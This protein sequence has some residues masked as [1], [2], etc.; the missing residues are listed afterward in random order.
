MKQG[1]S[2]AVEMIRVKH[3]SGMWSTLHFKSYDQGR[4]AF[5]GTEIDVIW[6][7]EEPPLPI[8]TECVTRT[9]TNDGMVMLTFTPLEGMSDVVMAFLNPEGG[10][11]PGPI[12]YATWDDVPHLTQ[13]A[14]DELWRLIPPYQRDARSK[15]IPQ[16]G[17]GAIYPVP[18]SEI[19]CEPFAIPDFWP[20]VYALDV[21]W[22]RTAAVWGARDPENGRIY[23]YSEHYQG[24]LEP[25]THAAAI[26]S[27]G[28]YIHGVVDPAARGRSQADGIQL[29]GMYTDNGLTLVPAKN[30]VEAG[31]YTVWQ[32][33]VGGQLK[34]FKTLEN[35]LR[36]FRLYRR[37]EKGHV[38]KHDDH[39]MDTMR[40][41]IMSG[42]ESMQT[43][44]DDAVKYHEEQTYVDPTRSESWMG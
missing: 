8:Y 33:L 5:Q 23:L 3:S 18:E 39:L 15:G 17:S 29:M 38:V 16:L 32:A 36:E 12:T 1:V 9:M 19:T 22:N 42:R 26:R 41:L 28:A 6:L 25:A 27:R 4:D 37:D 2:E 40:Y 20:R 43:K 24:S 14:K 10:Q 31:I 30:A 7:D 35:L 44:A 11:P 21:G 13:A 34:V